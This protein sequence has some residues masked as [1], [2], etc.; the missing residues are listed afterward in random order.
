M[1]I[2]AS[3]TK[4]TVANLDMQITQYSKPCDRNFHGSFKVVKMKDGETK[5]LT[6]QGR[7]ALV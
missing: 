5:K 3:R 1:E 7:H 6:R 4:V 2:K